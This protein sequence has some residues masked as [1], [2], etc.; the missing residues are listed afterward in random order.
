MQHS[1]ESFHVGLSKS[2]DKYLEAKLQLQHS[3]GLGHKPNVIPEADPDIRGAYRKVE[4]GWHPVAGLA[5][6]WFAEQTGLG[7]MITENINRYPDPTQHWA[8]LVDQYSHELWMVS[9]PGPS[10]CLDVA[11][12]DVGCDGGSLCFG[13]DEHLDVIYINGVINREEW[14]TFEVGKTRFNDEALRQAGKMTI[15]VPTP[16][17][18]SNSLTTASRSAPQARWSS[19]TCGRRSPGTT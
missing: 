11:G 15:G 5:G 16:D 7:K 10:S 17:P 2:K 1:K 19:L 8:I 3:L 9:F 6:K 12:R 13:Q 18:C 14:H 4:I